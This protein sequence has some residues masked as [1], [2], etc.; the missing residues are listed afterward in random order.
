MAAVIF[1]TAAVSLLVLVLVPP[2]GVE[3]FLHS[4]LSSS[5]WKRVSL[6]LPTNSQSNR[7]N[8]GGHPLHALLQE[9]DQREKKQDPPSE[10]PSCEGDAAEGTRHNN[11]SDDFSLHIGRALDTLRNEYPHLLTQSPDYTLYD[12]HNMSLCV[13]LPTAPLTALTY[14]SVY[15]LSRYKMVWD[16]LHTVLA[17]V[18]NMDQSYMSSVKLCHDRVRGNVLRVH[19]HAVLLPR[20]QKPEAAS[21]GVVVGASSS[22]QHHPPSS[23]CH[24]WDGISVYELDW[25]TGKIVQHRVEQVVY[26]HSAVPPILVMDDVMLRQ[27][28]KVIGGGI[29][30]RLVEHSTDGS[31][32]GSLSSSSSSSS[33]NLSPDNEMGNFMVQFR[34]PMYHSFRPSSLFAMEAEQPAKRPPSVP[35]TANNNNNK[36][37]LPNDVVAL[38]I[39]PST[40]TKHDALAV[41]ETS[42]LA[43]TAAAADMVAMID[44][45]AFDAKNKSRQKFGLQPLSVEE[46]VNIENQVEQLARTQQE[47]IQEAKLLAQQQQAEKEAAAGPSI[48]DK[49]FGSVM[50]NLDTCESNF[51]CVRPQVC[52][53]YVFAKK[54]CTSGSPIL[55]NTSKQ[56][57]YAR[58]PVYGGDNKPFPPQ[59]R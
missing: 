30:V 8:K 43:T 45:V 9:S 2:H 38:S 35:T 37:P 54:C 31:S 14:N 55:S 7:H 29:P 24:H 22:H 28:A 26:T 34:S 10:S 21:T 50:K 23:K 18:Y 53:D 48:F 58:I 46:F 49:V 40:D 4:P 51:D 12:E 19:W 20:W 41:D 3:A 42:A 39:T 27:A 32:C 56:L 5:S 52:C 44:M 13:D 33:S 11:D 15:G 25:T 36:L 6:L 17:L 47:A 57:Q 1:A 59:Q 16:M